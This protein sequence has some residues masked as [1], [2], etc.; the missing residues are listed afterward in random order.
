VEESRHFKA[1]SGETNLRRRKFLKSAMTVGGA[2]L[3][4]PGAISTPPPRS[5]AQAA[6]GEQSTGAM[7]ALAPEN[8]AALL[9]K[10][11][12]S[13]SPE[14]RR[15]ALKVYSTCVLDKIH[16]PDPPLAHPWIAPGGHYYGQWLWDTMFVVD[17]LAVLPGQEA[18]IRGVF[19]NYWDFQQRWDAVKPDFMHGMVANFI[20]PFGEKGRLDGTLWRTHPAYSQD[21]LLAWGMERVYLRSHDKELLRAGLVPLENFHEWYWRERDITNIG[22]VGVGAYSGN[23]QQAR[24]EAYDHEVDLDGLKMIPHPGRATGAENG[25]WYGDIAVPS[26]SSYLLVS[27]RALV[28][29]ATLLSDHAMAARRRARIAKGLAAI[30]KYMWDEKA[31]CFAA[32]RIE[33][34]EKIPSISVGGFIPLM[35]AAPGAKQAAIMAATLTTPAWATPLPV[36]SMAST[37][38]LYSSR[39]Y[40][41]GDVWP[42]LNYQ[43]ATGLAAYGHR[44]LTAHIADAILANELKAGISERYDS[45]SGAP[46]GEPG[47]GMSCS[48]LSTVLD[49]LTSAKYRMHVRRPRP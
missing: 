42:A 14:L 21:P 25:N 27:E 40:W 7:E 18:I 48:A 33:T 3:F 2:A 13:N 46:L 11:L 12:V 16:A 17:L 30:R 10:S 41:R 1:D 37:N 34:L 47:L 20:A 44:D 28:R 24:Y 29:M 49:G 9:D 39:K 45:M 36:P 8:L 6:A 19:Q 43:I 5:L 31:G 4:G 15:F 38:P 23:T 22:L 32:V 35:A 26:V